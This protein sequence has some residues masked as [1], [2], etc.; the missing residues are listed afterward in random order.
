MTGSMRDITDEMAANEAVEK[1]EAHYKTIYNNTPVML[2]SINPQG[3]LISVSDYWLK[4]MGYERKEVIGRQAVDFLTEQSRRYAL[5]YAQ[6]ELR[7]KGYI[8]DVSY[9]FVK[10]TVKESI[11]CYPPLPKKI[12]KE[13]SSRISVLLLM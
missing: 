2:H 1:S 9:Q 12:L 4:A 7:K 3:V 13:K 6:P 10:K 11:S 5:E 8:D